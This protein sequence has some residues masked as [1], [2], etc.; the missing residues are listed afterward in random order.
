[1]N[2]NVRDILNSGKR[3]KMEIIAAIVA[4][5]QKPS[6]ITILMDKMNLSHP[7]LK[8]Y[9]K[10]MLKLRLIESLEVV[11]KAN[12]KGQV[13]QS[14]EKGLIFLTTYCDILRIVY[15]EDFLQQANNLAITCLKYCKTA[16]STQ[17]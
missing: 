9:M 8:K 13:F 2:D 5:T 4:M 10:L 1:M 3:D 17:E 14:T 12:E 16:E 15:G 6:K 7:M 11:T